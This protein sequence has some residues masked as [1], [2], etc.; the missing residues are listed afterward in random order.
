[1]WVEIWNGLL[2][3]FNCSQRVV[4]LEIFFPQAREP[5]GVRFP[6]VVTLKAVNVAPSNAVTSK[7]WASGEKA[8]PQGI[9]SLGVRPR[10]TRSPEGSMR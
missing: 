6:S 10:N 2:A 4:M 9:L 8:K 1:M 5:A 7:N 3:D